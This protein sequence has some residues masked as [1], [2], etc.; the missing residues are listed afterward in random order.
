MISP[1]MHTRWHSVCV[2]VDCVNLGGVFSNFGFGLRNWKWTGNL[3]LGWGGRGGNSETQVKVPRY[4]E[5]GG[6]SPTSDLGG[7][8]SNFGFGL[9]KKSWK[10]GFL[11]GGYSPTS[12][13]DLG[14][15]VGNL[16]FGGGGILQLRNFGFGL[17][18]KSWKFGFLDLG[19]V[20]SNFGFGLR[21]KSW[22]FGFS[23][24]GGGGILKLSW[25]IGVFCRIWTKFSTTPA[26]SCIT[27]SLS[28]TTLLL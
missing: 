27:D 24:R 25:R 26:G 5:L 28:H 14:K 9:R 8:F 10:F 20:F 23:L 1:T 2:C 21:K 16:D 12:D 4:H 3:D 17:R 19:G 18:K 22:K 15:K 7:V 11:G 6:Y 13:L